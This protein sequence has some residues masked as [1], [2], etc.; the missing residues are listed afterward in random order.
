MP[1]EKYYA[2]E[3]EIMFFD[4]ED[5]IRQARLTHECRGSPCHH[6]GHHRLFSACTRHKC[7]VDGRSNIADKQDR[8]HKNSRPVFYV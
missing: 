5:V 6:Q 4:S 3:I 2:P 8:E 1:K 7:R